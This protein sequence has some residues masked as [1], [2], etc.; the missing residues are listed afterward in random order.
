MHREILCPAGPL[1]VLVSKWLLFALE[2]SVPPVHFTRV[3]V[4]VLR[5]ANSWVLPLGCSE[6]LHH[7][8]LLTLRCPFSLIESALELLN[9][10]GM[11]CWKMQRFW[12]FVLWFHAHLIPRNGGN[13]RRIWKVGQ[14]SVQGPCNAYPR[15]P[16]AFTLKGLLPT[17]SFN[18]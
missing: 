13:K 6:T 16:N 11:K 18:N 12:I 15:V 17:I 8:K 14:G 2:R 4:N 1:V 5:D 10:K 9:S 3:A 7:I